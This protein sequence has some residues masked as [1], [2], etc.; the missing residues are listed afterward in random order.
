MSELKHCNAK[1]EEPAIARKLVGLARRNVRLVVACACLIVFVELLEDVLAG[2]LMR[3]DAWAYALIVENMR[4]DWL[5]P[6]MEGFSALAAPLSLLAMLAI[7]AAFAPGRRPGATCALN[8]VLVVA[9][10]AALKVI[11]ARP[12]PEGFRLIAESGFSF[13]SGHSMVAMAFFGLLIWLV[14][15]YE[16]DKTV[17]NACCAAFG[18]IIVMI[19][20]SRIYLGVHY[21]SDVIGG[22]CVSLLWLAFYT[23][24]IA[25]AM[26]AD[27]E[28]RRE[29]GE[30]CEGKALGE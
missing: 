14:W 16:S 19:G 6:V 24:V 2:D 30:G 18:L 13:P 28:G 25:P 8:L 10:N 3:V 15:R 12:R 1:T 23:R 9:L 22:F 7:I 20:I 29:H 5:T 27:K 4:A 17:R 21:A 11:V 26:L